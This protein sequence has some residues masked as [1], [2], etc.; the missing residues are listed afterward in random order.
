MPDLSRINYN[1]QLY[2]L[3]DSAARNTLS[4]LSAS[5]VSLQSANETVLSALQEIRAILM[6]Q[7]NNNQGSTTAIAILDQAILDLSALA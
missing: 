5:V 1:G 7:G 6:S 2:T 4:A 3:K